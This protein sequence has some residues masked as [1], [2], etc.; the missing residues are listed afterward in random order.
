MKNKTMSLIRVPGGVGIRK[1]DLLK[2][3]YHHQLEPQ[4][5]WSK[6][7]HSRVNSAFRSLCEEFDVSVTTDNKIA[8]NSL[9]WLSSTWILNKNN[10]GT[11]HIKYDRQKAEFFAVFP[12]KLW[13]EFAS[14]LELIPGE[15]F[16][17]QTLDSKALKRSI[18]AVL[19]E[20]FLCAPFILSPRRQTYVMTLPGDADRIQ[21]YLTDISVKAFNR[22]ELTAPIP[23]VIKKVVAS[24]EF[25]VK[26]YDQDNKNKRT[27]W[28]IHSKLIEKLG[29]DYLDE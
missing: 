15:V 5:S 23:E 25:G 18:S 12:S 11:V 9:T 7:N 16:S 3:S 14:R 2:T 21:S 1:L 24:R 22:T 10:W 29:Q 20:N 6:V 13:K 27:S 4:K 28:D 26:V 19:M 8:R 17:H